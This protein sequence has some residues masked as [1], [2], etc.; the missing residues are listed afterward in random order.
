MLRH[1]GTWWHKILYT[2][3]NKEYNI[4]HGTQKTNSTEELTY[5]LCIVKTMLQCWSSDLS[6]C[7]SGLRCLVSSASQPCLNNTYVSQLPNVNRFAR[8]RF[9]V[10]LYLANNAN[11]S[12]YIYFFKLINISGWSTGTVLSKLLKFCWK[13]MSAVHEFINVHAPQEGNLDISYGRKIY[14]M[15]KLLF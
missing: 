3:Y 12:I 14:I 15:I 4:L 6:L 13:E 8:V 9:Q 1:F 11:K 2:I 7:H 5:K 10:L